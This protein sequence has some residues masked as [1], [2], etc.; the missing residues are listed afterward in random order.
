MPTAKPA[1]LRWKGNE[2]YQPDYKY[3]LAPTPHPNR[4]STYESQVAPPFLSIGDMSQLEEQDD[5]SDEEVNAIET[6]IQNADEK[7]LDYFI[8]RLNKYRRLRD[9]GKLKQRKI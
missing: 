6:V 4:G 8:E 9:K 5:L 7:E 1:V 3:P 2:E